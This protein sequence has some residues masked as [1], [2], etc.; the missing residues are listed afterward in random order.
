[1]SVEDKLAL[2]KIKTSTVLNE[3]GHY[4][5]ETPFKDGGEKILD[6]HVK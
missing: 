6:S 5:V 2:H 3:N 4:Q 1:M